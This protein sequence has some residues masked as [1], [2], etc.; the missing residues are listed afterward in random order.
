[1]LES[2]HRNSITGNT[3]RKWYEKAEDITYYL[4][5]PRIGRDKVTGG[6]LSRKSERH[7]RFATA[8][9]VFYA[10]FSKLC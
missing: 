4:Y 3:E 6:L 8:T 1:M 10:F 5:H 9:G 2:N 7:S